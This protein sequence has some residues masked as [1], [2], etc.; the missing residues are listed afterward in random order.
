MD[1]RTSSVQ[2]NTMKDI[3]TIAYVLEEPNA[4]FKLTEVILDE[5]RADELLIEM[6]YAGICHTVRCPPHSIEIA[7][8]TMQHH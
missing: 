3:E 1:H 7:A 5:V 8:R 4:D 6:K 2:P